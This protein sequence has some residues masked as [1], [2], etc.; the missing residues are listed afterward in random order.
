MRAVFLVAIFFGLIIGGAT[1][2]FRALAGGPN[3]SSP[4]AGSPAK[5]PEDTPASVA[6]RFATA[7]SAGN[8]DDLYALIDPQSQLTYAQAAFVSEYKSVASELTQTRLSA[9]VAAAGETNAR[10]SVHVATA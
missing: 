1:V 8:Y 4:S 10:L 3:S 6:Q 2:G 7:W 5:P 9:T